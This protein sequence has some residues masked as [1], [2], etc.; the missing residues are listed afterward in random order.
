MLSFFNAVEISKLKPSSIFGQLNIVRDDSQEKQLKDAH[1]VP[2]Y[3]KKGM[4][5]WWTRRAQGVFDQNFVH[6]S[7]LSDI[8]AERKIWWPTD[9]TR[10]ELTNAQF[11]VLDEAF[12]GG[13]IY[14]HFGHFVLDSLSRLYPLLPAIHASDKPVVFHYPRDSIS[15]EQIQNGYMGAFFDLLEIE[16][17]RIIFLD[18]PLKIKSLTY[19][20][21]TFSD[22]N[23]TVAEVNKHFPTLSD[24]KKSSRRGFV[25]KSKLKTGTA[26]PTQGLE[27]DQ[28]FESMGFDIIYPE[29]LNLKDQ[30]D[31]IQSYDLLVGFPSSFF[32]LK[33]FCKNGARLVIMFPDID[34]ILHVNFLNIDIGAGFSDFFIPVESSPVES[35][36]GFAKAF[37]V[38]LYQVYELACVLR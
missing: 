23:F 21:P 20:S 11:D 6:V 13:T 34:E 24:V 35:P 9:E 1:L 16:F 14:D 37:D 3:Y 19:H 5:S 26:Y 31:I 15:V 36:E 17:N 22:A 18:N 12:Y 33:L 27:I 29:T 4:R 28:I 7:E 30:V 32:H 2:S 8:R 25:S 38:E 10:A